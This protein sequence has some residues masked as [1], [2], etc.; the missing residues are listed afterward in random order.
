MEAE[1]LWPPAV[2]EGEFSIPNAD[3]TGKLPQELNGDF[4][5]L[6][7]CWVGPR[8]HIIDSRGILARLRFSAGRVKLA[9][10]RVSSDT[11]AAEEEGRARLYLR[12][13]SVNSEGLIGSMLGYLRHRG[14]LAAAQGERPRRWFVAANAGLTDFDGRLLCHSPFSRPVCVDA[15][16]LHTVGTQQN[17]R[18][19]SARM[20]VD[21]AVPGGSRVL[22]FGVEP[23]K[24][25]RRRELH[26]TECA[27]DGTLLYKQE[28]ALS[29]ATAIFPGDF[30]PL[31]RYYVFHDT[32]NWQRHDS[33]WQRPVV[34]LGYQAPLDFAHTSGEGRLLFVPR[35]RAGE[36][37]SVSTGGVFISAFGGVVSDLP[38]SRRVV[39][40]AVCHKVWRPSSPGEQRWYDPKMYP[41]RLCI[42]SVD[43]QKNTLDMSPVEEA[44]V[45]SPVC[46]PERGGLHCRYVF[47][48]GRSE[49]HDERSSGD[50]TQVLKIDLVGRRRQCFRTHEVDAV[51]FVPRRTSRAA[52]EQA[53]DD[54]WLIVQQRSKSGCTEIAIYDAAELFTGPVCA[55]QLRRQ[56]PPA[57]STFFRSVRAESRL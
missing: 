41:G 22:G 33:V 10:R 17:P 37:F 2:Q 56:F 8:E 13:G 19:R 31:R 25:S 1:R 5:A 11:A 49:G 4:F 57:T 48:R 42:V 55:V 39:F 27:V 26:I 32:P 20:R 43:I 18:I 51:C 16:T 50:F 28:H 29:S 45:D 35:E 24:A 15:E 12:H 9:V 30:L 23:A 6:A 7:P 47:C 3:I 21:S 14:W 46:H 44:V 52:E 38:E 53:E 54:G 34:A 36:P 40:S